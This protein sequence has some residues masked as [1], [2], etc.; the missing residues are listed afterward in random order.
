MTIFC[1]FK[2]KAD[3]RSICDWFSLYQN[4]DSIQNRDRFES[5]GISNLKSIK[6]TFQQFLNRNSNIFKLTFLVNKPKKIYLK[7]I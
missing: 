6:I 5:L 7:Q 2:K 1:F 4:D 3:K